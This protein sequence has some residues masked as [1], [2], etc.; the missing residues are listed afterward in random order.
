M[1]LISSKEKINGE[2]I[3]GI[4]LVVLSLLFIFAG[5]V[6]PVWAIILPGDYLILMLGLAFIALGVVTII[7]HKNLPEETNLHHH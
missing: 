3:T 7:R 2:T 5:S 4:A 6:N 1:S